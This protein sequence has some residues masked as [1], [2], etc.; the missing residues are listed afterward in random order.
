[1]QELA[2]KYG[3]V[4]QGSIVVSPSNRK[5]YTFRPSQSAKV[6]FLPPAP[7]AG[8][9]YVENTTV[10]SRD[11]YSV[12]EEAT[13]AEQ[14]DRR[15]QTACTTSEIDYGCGSSFLFGPEAPK[16]PPRPPPY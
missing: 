15:L 12:R 9:S 16:Q 3:C 1:M 2:Q 8:Q 4:P 5:Q 11:E 7:E 6:K 13:Y 10:A 14:V